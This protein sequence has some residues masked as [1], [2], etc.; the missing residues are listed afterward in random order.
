MYIYMYTS[1]LLLD[2]SQA[3]DARPEKFAHKRVLLFQS[4]LLLCSLVG[5]YIVLKMIGL[6]RQIYIYIYTYIYIDAHTH[7][8]INPNHAPSGTGRTARK[9]CP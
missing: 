3:L 5:C 4:I 1:M 2:V 6:T 7:T 9:V 8:R